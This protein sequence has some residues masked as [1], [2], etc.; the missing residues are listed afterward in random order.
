[1]LRRR[2]V[3]LG[4][5]ACRRGRVAANSGAIA[6][7]QE[8]HGGRRAPVQV[9][10]VWANTLGNGGR[11]APGR[12]FRGAHGRP[13][14]GSSGAVLQMASQRNTDAMRC[15]RLHDCHWKCVRGCQVG[16]CCGW[17]LRTE[18]LRGNCGWRGCERT[19]CE[20]T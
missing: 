10:E 14:H 16:M 8:Q 3:R 6:A 7:V 5:S 2:V 18:L 15:R 4:G 12:V 20:V 11:Q 9:S 13:P 17:C 19:G 1:M